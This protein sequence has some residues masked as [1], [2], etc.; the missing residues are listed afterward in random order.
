MCS[1]AEIERKINIKKS[2]ENEIGR[3]NLFCFVFFF[4]FSKSGVK[5]TCL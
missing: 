3:L 5:K 1:N 4:G 2:F